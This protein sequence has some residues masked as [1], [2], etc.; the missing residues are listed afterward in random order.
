MKYFIFLV[1][2]CLVVA[3]SLAWNSPAIS[4]PAS[5]AST[6]TGVTLN[7][8][9]VS[10]SD[11][12]EMQIDTSPNFDSPIFDEF[13]KGYINSSSYNNDTEEF[14]SNLFFGETYFW[15]VRAVAA[16][17]TS[18]WNLRSFNTRD[19][20]TL[21][22]PS[23]W[24]NTWTGVEF[25]WSSHHGVSNYEIQIDTSLSFNSPAFQ[26]DVDAYV[27]SS[28]S[29]YDTEEFFSN[30]Y[31]GEL[32]YWRVRATNAVD[33]SE[34]T[35]SNIH[36]R[37]YVTL[38]SPIAFATSWTGVEFDWS[39]HHGVGFYEIQID[40]SVNFNSGAFQSTLETYVNSS[41][42][43]YDTEEFF[44]DLYFGATY[45]WRVRAINSVDTSAWTTRTLTTRDYVTLSSPSDGSTTWSGLEFNWSSHY[46]VDFYEIQID[47]SLSFNSVAF[48]SDVEAY[49][50]TSSSNYDTEEIFSDLYF[51]ATYYWRVR[52]INAVDTSAW[53]MRSFTTR[54]YVTLSYPSEG[55]NTWTGLEFNW[56][57]HY[58]VDYYELEVDTSLSFNSPAY[59]HDIEAYTNTSSS[60]YDTE[61]FISD[62]YFGANYH[63]RVR[64]INAVDTSDW[65]V[66]SFTTRDYVTLSSPSEGAETWTGLEFNWNSHYGVDFYEIQVDTTT[67]FN[68]TALITDI[69]A[70][71]NTSSSNDDTEE[72]LNNLYFGET[73]YWR[74]RALNAVDTSAWTMR[75]IQTRDYVTLSSPSNMAVNQ[76]NS[77]VNLNWNS[78]YGVTHYELEWDTTNLYNST[79][80]HNL[81][82]TYI[83][84]SSSNSDTY[85]SSG[86]LLVNQN[87]FWRVRAINT[88]DTSAWTA[89]V[90]STGASIT[91]P[92]EPSLISP[93]NLSSTLLTDVDFSWNNAS[94]AANYELQYSIDPTFTTAVTNTTTST[95]LS[96]N[97][98][99]INEQY[100]WKVRSIT[101]GYC[102]DWS[103]VWSFVTPTCASTSSIIGATTCDNYLSPSGL[104]NWTST[105]IYT[106]TILNAGGCDSII[107]VDLI[108]SNSSS[109]TEN[110]S[111][112]ESY[113]WNGNVYQTSGT[114]IEVLS[115]AAGCDSLLTLNL[116]ITGSS[117][118]II[119]PSACFEYTSPSGNYVW[120]NTGLYMDTISNSLG[121]DSIITVNL[122]INT[123]DTATITN[124]T[125]ISAN[126]AGA[127]YQWLTCNNEYAAIIGANSQNY[128]PQSNGYYAVEI[129][130]DGCVDTSACIP[131]MMLDLNSI[132]TELHV[133]FYPNPCKG[134][135]TVKLG[136]IQPK[137]KA[138]IRNMVGQIISINEF[139]MISEFDLNIDGAAG[140]YAIEL[141]TPQG[142]EI[143]KVIKE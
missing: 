20:V 82:E 123:V 103:V 87:Y 137:V 30:L 79:Q 37:D 25:D 92:Q 86:T 16:A 141:K 136:S 23:Q 114:Y 72:Y 71:T 41:S 77:G 48:Q 45:H 126:V 35:V 96:V 5:G 17:D 27:N 4:S 104:Y 140:V 19:Y 68:S 132:S 107:T 56:N 142:V 21:S 138:T 109:S 18:S 58:Y 3:D 133:A 81:L 13:M 14:V 95:N 122:I 59:Q 70:Y 73:Y 7:W 42:S 66:R 116:T 124:D 50:N 88:N 130:Q 83:N 31:F 38:S 24:A 49:I 2:C 108:V 36:T 115:N 112:C 57:S 28:S 33:T 15:R 60:N 129:I 69:E 40:T 90:F 6:W 106:D 51:G 34:W 98:L 125:M 121:C 102:S 22:S 85:Q 9:A 46:G 55:A 94:N 99:D 101:G 78:H 97:G 127:A 119:N 39:S 11:F 117:L 8:N 118:S 29:N 143:F 105:G 63:W 93:A 84:S 75:T 10:G 120:N 44:S 139:D 67:N 47:T 52:A 53:T 134:N 131:F 64:A 111:A 12:Y 135:L 62:L 110:V 65:T 89:R 1:C 128:V 32:Y 91:L 61:E 43:N 54:D 76:S 26:S 80:L 74:V 100:Y 113:S